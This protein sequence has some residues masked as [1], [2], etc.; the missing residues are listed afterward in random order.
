MMKGGGAGAGGFPGDPP[1]Q[2]WGG[3]VV[4]RS[5]AGGGEGGVGREWGVG[6]GTLLFYHSSFSGRESGHVQD[7][8]CI[9][10]CHPSRG[11]LTITLEDT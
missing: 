7:K 3:G 9:R 8:I 11:F 1:H 4:E 10:L 2:H 6:G 5:R